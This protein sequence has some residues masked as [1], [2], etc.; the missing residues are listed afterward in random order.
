MRLAEILRN[1]ALAVAIA[2]PLL[3]IAVGGAMLYLAIS[4]SETDQ[5]AL[6]IQQQQPLSKT[7][8]RGAKE[9]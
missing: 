6:P 8:W 2:I 3:S 1:P 4:T 9:S 5:S 7:S